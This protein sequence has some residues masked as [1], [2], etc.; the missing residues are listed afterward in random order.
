MDYK[1]TTKYWI[2]LAEYDLQTAKVMLKGK[3]YLYVGFMC[4]QV[5]EKILKAYYVN[6]QEKN[7]DYTHNLSSLSIKSE[8][9]NDFSEKQKDFI[10]LL[11]PLNI[12]SRYP[13]YKDRLLKSLNKTKCK[14]ILSNT[15][16][17]FNWIKMKF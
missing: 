3:R 2:E 13:T 12:E 7:P 11:D 15:M 17:L 10:D 5:I 4:H 14:E 6:K 8:V 16:E 9:Y 1:E